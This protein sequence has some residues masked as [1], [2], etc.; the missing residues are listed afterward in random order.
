MAN[1]NFTEWFC[2]GGNF[3]PAML[4]AIALVR[5]AAKQMGAIVAFESDR[6]VWTR[7][8]EMRPLSRL[9]A[10]AQAPTLTAIVAEPSS[11]NSDL[12]S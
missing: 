3:Y 2:G 10:C 8:T 4:A 5:L 1:A 7:G 12:C 9:A 11:D 6:I